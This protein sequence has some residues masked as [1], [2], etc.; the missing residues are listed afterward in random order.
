MREDGNSPERQIEFFESIKPNIGRFVKE[1]L[2]NWGLGKNDIRLVDEAGFIATGIPIFGPEIL[3]GL[4][5][6]QDW[7]TVGDPAYHGKSL[8]VHIDFLVKDSLYS[9]PRSSQQHPVVIPLPLSV[10]NEISN[11][12]RIDVSDLIK[13]RDLFFALPTT[14][15]QFGEIDILVPEPAPH[16]KAFATD[17]ILNYPFI[18]DDKLVMEDKFKEWYK[19]LALIRDVSRQLS[20]LD[21]YTAALE[22]L[23]ASKQRLTVTNWAWL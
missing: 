2:F 18:I 22:M 15:I 3:R 4:G 8:N 9:G 5:Q 20:R 13:G 6:A 23:E 17:T 10:A 16:V 21:V 1:K 11:Q 7:S 19:K 12:Y 14:Q